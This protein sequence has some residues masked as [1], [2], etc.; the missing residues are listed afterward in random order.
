MANQVAVAMAD[1]RSQERMRLLLDLT[2]PSVSKLELR[3]LL[4]E[5]SASVRQVMQ[6]DVV[7][8]ALP[9]RETGEVRPYAVDVSGRLEP[10]K[11]G[12]IRSVCK[13]LPLW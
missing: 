1:A 8:V 2:N 5:V 12:R 9:D 13:G 10:V 6:C 4:Q 11:G 7:G 3:E